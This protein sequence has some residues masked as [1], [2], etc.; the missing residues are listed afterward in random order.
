M[1]EQLPHTTPPAVW[2]WPGVWG[3]LLGRPKGKQPRRGG[4]CQD[5]AIQPDTWSVPEWANHKPIACQALPKAPPCAPGTVA[6]SKQAATGFAIHF[7]MVSGLRHPL[8]HRLHPSREMELHR[9]SAAPWFWCSYAPDPAFLGHRS[10]RD[11]APGVPHHARAISP[12][13]PTGM[14]KVSSSL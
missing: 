14:C 5:E 9:G 10:L 12:Q 6:H 3:L 1:P 11:P 4:A 13:G 8:Q 7:V 2:G